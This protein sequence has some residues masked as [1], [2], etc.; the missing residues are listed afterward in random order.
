MAKKFFQK[1]THY[2]VTAKYP[3]IPF[4]ARSC[5]HFMLASDYKAP[6]LRRDFVELFWCLGGEG[7]FIINNRSYPLRPGEVCFYVCD[8]VH[9]VSCGGNFFHSRWVT[10]E[11]PAVMDIWRGLQLPQTPRQVG[12]CPEELFV[13]LE[14]EI[15]NY[16]P[17]GLR[18]ASATAFRILMLAASHMPAILPSHD[19]IQQ[20]Q[21]VID[22]QYR[23]PN[24]NVGGIADRLG[25]NRSQLSR[26]FHA[27]FGVTPAKYLINRRIQYGL[28][29]LANSPHKI[30]E[31]ATRSGFSDPN[32]F[33][34]VIK[35]YTG[36]NRKR[37]KS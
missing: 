4:R 30:K 9:Q 34:K 27:V 12:R 21:R 26:K 7:R 33:T 32:Y 19:Y 8:D 31:I 11:G 35:K 17:D 25:V 28:Q 10:F 23:N 18:L 3:D 6:P 5:G 15:L 14:E 2:C 24:L 37:T 22:T 16:T 29:Q 1:I 13:Q 36:M 20:A